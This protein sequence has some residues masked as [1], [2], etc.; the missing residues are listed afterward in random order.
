M[1]PSAGCGE[2]VVCHAI[3][4][5]VDGLPGDEVIVFRYGDADVYGRRD[6]RWRRIGSLAG[7]HCGGDAEAVAKGRFKLV[8]P[9]PIPSVM[10]DGRRQVFA[11][12]PN[13]SHP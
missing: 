7:G 3:V 9:E 4:G 5:E 8:A 11:P 1:E 10:V 2:G 13:C 12:L 6:G